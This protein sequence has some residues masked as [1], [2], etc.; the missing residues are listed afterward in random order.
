MIQTIL[1]I[2]K[3]LLEAFPSLE[4]IIRSMRKSPQEN[5]DSNVEDLRKEIDEFKRT[6]RPGGK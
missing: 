3:A 2:F 6:G 5:V 4:R 1:G